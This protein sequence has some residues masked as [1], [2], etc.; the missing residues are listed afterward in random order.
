M[1]WWAQDALVSEVAV[2]VLTNALVS[3]VLFLFPLWHMCVV[4][5]SRWFTNIWTSR[6]SQAELDA[7]HLGPEF[8]IADRVADG[9]K[10]MF[11]SLVLAPILPLAPL[12]GSA[13]LLLQHGLSRFFLLRLSR[14][15]H[16]YDKRIM[17]S[18][19]RLC[20]I[21]L[22]PVPF[23]S[24]LLLRTPH[25]MSVAYLWG[26]ATEVLT[27]WSSSGNFMV[28]LGAAVTVLLSVGLVAKT[29][30]SGLRFLCC[31][32]R[33][34]KEQLLSQTYWDVQAD[35]AVHYHSTNPV[36]KALPEEVNPPILGADAEPS[37][38]TPGGLAM[39]DLLCSPDNLRKMFALLETE[40]EIS[41]SKIR[42][43]LHGSHKPTSSTCGSARNSN[44][45]TGCTINLPL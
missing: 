28:F 22:A 21:A 35:F 37:V 42:S 8:S 40:V 12:C 18:V 44:L 19:S 39:G 3:P 2:L 31:G 32:C 23:I 4:V 5:P 30:V 17:T 25:T 13:S 33:R 41:R 24:L 38:G 10:T 20:S 15:P 34:E 45:V 9:I 29:G 26:C 27:P 16:W 7:K 1:D 43:S 6:Q 36:Y 14:R 11:L